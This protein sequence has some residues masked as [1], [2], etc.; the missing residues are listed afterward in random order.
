M[1]DFEFVSIILSIVV[2][3][4]ITRV[5]AGLA[6]IVEHRGQLHMNWLSVGWAT[7]V[8]SWSVAFWLGTINDTRGLETWTVGSFGILLFM[9]LGLY[10]LAAVALPT[11]IQAG[12]DLEAHFET[13]RRPFF[14]MFAAWV[15]LSTVSALI[16]GSENFIRLGP[17]FWIG[18]TA[19]L[20]VA[21]LGF[22]AAHKL[23]HVVILIA[24]LS[25]TVA[26]IVLRM[27]VI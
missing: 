24:S 20:A 6:A 25:M 23:V 16:W 26:L 3:L 21:L 22:L 13:V 11:R 18:Q 27:Y 14:A 7:T 17:P 5:L 19:S 9:A 4:T 15:V 12:V 1:S 8:L 2:G 10:F